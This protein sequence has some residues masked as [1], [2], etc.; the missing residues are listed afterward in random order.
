M[1][2]DPDSLLVQAA[3]ARDLLS[4]EEAEQCLGAARL[5]GRPVAEVLVE[6]AL[7][8]PRTIESLGR[9]LASSG[10]SSGAAAQDTA[11]VTPTLAP[12]P[13]AAP[14]RDG[15]TGDDA[16][17]HA[18]AEPGALRPAGAETW[19][20]YQPQATTG[21]HAPRVIG[22]DFEL[23][24]PLGQGGMGMVFRARQ[25]SLQ[26]DVAIKVLSPEFAATRQAAER[27]AREARAAAAVNHPHVIGMIA[28]GRDEASGRLYMAMELVRGG[29]AERLAEQAGGRLPE[30]RAL[31][32]IRDCARG[33]VAIERA[34]LVH[35]DIKPANM[36]VTE[37]GAAK[38]ADLGLARSQDG[39]DRVTQSGLVVGTPAYMPPEQAEG[40]QDLDVR[41]DIYALGASLY[42]LLTGHKPFEGPNA[43]A[44]LSKVVRGAPP[45]PRSH[46]PSLSPAVVALVLKAMARE[47]ADR[48]PD[49]AA[50]LADLERVLQAGRV[51]LAPPARASSA[52]RQVVVR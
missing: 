51:T 35:R 2:G 22:G 7:L 37:D 47:R 6:R 21:A 34:G 33:L 8:A 3:L 27:F 42:R 44:V 5:R 28:A 38:L 11:D 36:F 43:M 14:P 32:L 13:A 48:H 30:R 24:E 23:L 40:A 29:D 41:A 19:L 15:P 18:A 4:A 20:T 17:T 46:V 10:A 39:D 52:R 49:A 12:G 16:P 45:D 25:R 1:S 31:E 9:A 26:R 50:L